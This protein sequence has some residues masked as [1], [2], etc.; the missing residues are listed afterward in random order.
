MRDMHVCDCRIG[1]ARKF[2]CSAAA[3]TAPR[4]GS[5]QAL[6]LAQSKVTLLPWKGLIPA[7]TAFLASHDGCS[8]PPLAPA[9]CDGGP[10]PALADL[11]EPDVPRPRPA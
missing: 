7:D 9:P 3:H 8:V 4:P 2:W 6:T 1:F 10:A 5:S 11:I